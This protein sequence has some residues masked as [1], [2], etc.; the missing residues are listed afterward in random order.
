APVDEAALSAITL[1]TDGLNAGAEGFFFNAGKNESIGAVTKLMNAPLGTDAIEECGAGPMELTEFKGG[2]TLN[3]L[4][5]ALVGWNLRAPIGDEEMAPALIAIA[6]DVNVGMTR[7]QIEAAAGYEAIPDSTLGDEFTLEGGI[8]GFL[9]G[10]LVGWN[11]RAPI[12][13]E[14]MAPALI[15]I[16]GDVNVGM[17]REQIEAAAGYE[18][19]P[20]STLGD[21]FTLEGGIGGFLD[22]ENVG[23]L[24]AGTQCFFR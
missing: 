9:D 11:L 14:E 3:F 4:D 24:Y 12:G 18:A 8:G 1:N 19:I 13:D 5:G 21:E 15:A 10:A 2:L 6:G 16:A 22:G 23:M 20:D 7:E 17:T